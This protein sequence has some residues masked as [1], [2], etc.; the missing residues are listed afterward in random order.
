M[1]VVKTVSVSGI[2]VELV[3]MLG[4]LLRQG[5]GARIGSQRECW[6]IHHVSTWETQKKEP[7]SDASESEL[8]NYYIGGTHEYTDHLYFASGKF[9]QVGMGETVEVRVVCQMNEW[10]ATGLSQ[11]TLQ[12]WVR[13]KGSEISHR[14]FFYSGR[15]YGGDNDITK[16]DLPEKMKEEPPKKIKF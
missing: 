5:L 14:H 6:D 15:G 1:Q 16:S 11:W 4:L 7:A 10:H 13:T 2:Y 12:V 8:A 3:Q 9:I